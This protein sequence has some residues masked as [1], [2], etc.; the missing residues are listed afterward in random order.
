MHISLNLR[1]M[2]KPSGN[3]QETFPD[4]AQNN[5]K[6]NTKYLACSILWRIYDTII[7]GL[8]PRI[9]QLR[10]GCLA[11][12]SS[13]F[14]CRLGHILWMFFNGENINYFNRSVLKITMD[15]GS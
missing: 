10:A 13:A 8:S 3:W 15:Y 5:I 12:W 11:M 1:K 9:K 4:E 7:N 6:L 14:D 2:N